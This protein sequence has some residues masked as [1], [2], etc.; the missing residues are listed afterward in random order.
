MNDAIARCHW[1]TEDPLYLKYHDEEW[2]VPVHDDR[3]LF[4]KIVL[5]GLSW[6]TILKRRKNYRIAFDNF[7]IAKVA[8]YNDEDLERL[9]VNE[10]II[11]NRRKIH[12]AINNARR[13]LHIQKKYDTL[14]SFFWS[15][16]DGKTVQNTWKSVSEIP[17]ITAESTAMSKVLKKEGFTFVGPTSCYALMQALGMV[18]DHSIN[19]FRYTEIKALFM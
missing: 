18:N 5:E 15:F 11:R 7:D 12:S 3:L 10:G 1:N 6:I 14:D 13:T 2:G 19:C 4:E 8:R 16:V 9:V 17:A